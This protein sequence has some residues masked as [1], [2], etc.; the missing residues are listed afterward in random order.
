MSYF[1]MVVWMLV[2][3]SAPLVPVLFLSKFGN[4][5]KQAWQRRSNR[6]PQPQPA[7]TAGAPAQPA[8][9]P[10]WTREVAFT[11]LSGIVII[12]IVGL[13]GFFVVGREGADENT[14]AMNHRLGIV[15]LMG[16]M[17]LIVWL[18]ARFQR[19]ILDPRVRDKFKERMQYANP[20]LWGWLILV[21]IPLFHWVFYG[22]SPS[23]W[24]YWH[25]SGLFW[26]M[27]VVMILLAIPAGHKWAGAGSYRSALALVMFVVIVVAS[28]GFR[29]RNQQPSPSTASTIPTADTTFV[30]T[31]R[32]G[33][34]AEGIMPVGWRMDWWGDPTKFDSSHVVWRGQ[35]KVQ[36]FTT[37]PGVE[38]A[39]IKIRVYPCSIETPC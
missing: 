35:N 11:L 30:A 29:P 14:L 13:Y 10:F 26:P 32:P 37:K 3:L 1:E 23:A 17:G 33:Q 7:A 8:D 28:F 15:W 18:S 19:S 5:A 24:S 25:N 20:P 12:A 36:L 31:A 16:L 34:P 21:V 6:Q 27:N 2:V 22:L 39:E 9:A 4:Q 38:S